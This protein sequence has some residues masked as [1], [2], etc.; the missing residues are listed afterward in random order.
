MRKT[1]LIL[2]TC[3]TTCLM[4]QGFL[5][6]QEVTPPQKEIPSIDLE[7]TTEDG[8]GGVQMYAYPQGAHDI[9]APFPFILL[10]EGD[11]RWLIADSITKDQQISQLRSVI[12]T[13]VELHNETI[14]DFNVQL[15]K[16]NRWHTIATYGIPGG[17]I[18]GLVIGLLIG[19]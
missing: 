9:Y 2:L 4:A 7:W 11:A 12:N 14:K 17:I 3:I 19:G 15:E 5:Y 1:F 18:A 8:E 10:S 13:N 16:A 6:A